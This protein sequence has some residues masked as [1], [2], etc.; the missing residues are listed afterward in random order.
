MATGMMATGVIAAIEAV[1]A[2]GAIR[3]IEVVT[4][5]GIIMAT[6]VI[7]VMMI[8][9]TTVDRDFPCRLHRRDSVYF[10][11]RCL[12][13]ISLHQLPTFMVS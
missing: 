4:A 10:F 1:T 2:D 13:M 8:I 5:D 3:A 7:T 11:L 9:M 12:D 6:G